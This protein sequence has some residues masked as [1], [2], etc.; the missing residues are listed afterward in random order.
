MSHQPQLT[1]QAIVLELFKADVFGPQSLE[2]AYNHVQSHLRNAVNHADE[3]TLKEQAAHA[4]GMLNSVK[5]ESDPAR[6]QVW[7][8]VHAAIKAR[9]EQVRA[10]AVARLCRAGSAAT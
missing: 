6:M 7:D 10:V 9:L 2:A 1:L 8:T 4:W 3:A 5:T